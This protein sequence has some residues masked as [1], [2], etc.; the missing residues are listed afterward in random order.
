MSES[1]AVA[2]ETLETRLTLIELRLRRLRILSGLLLLLA[3][4]AAWAAIRGPG[5]DVILSQ[6]ILEDEAGRQRG[7]ISVTGGAPALAFFDSTGQ[8][9]G[10]LGLTQEGRPSLVFLDS[11][12]GALLSLTERSAGGSILQLSTPGTPSRV[13]LRSGTGDPSHIVLSG[14]DSVTL[15]LQPGSSSGLVGNPR[16]GDPR[17]P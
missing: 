3:A 6:I 2:A 4:S 7:V 1:P 17:V 13:T 11:R 8:L 15:T 9:R 14:P 16:E 12:G 10:T 5:K